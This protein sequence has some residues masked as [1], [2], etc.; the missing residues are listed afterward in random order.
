MFGFYS[1][2]YHSQ[3]KLYFH[4]QSLLANLLVVLHHKNACLNLPWVP[5]VMRHIYKWSICVALSKMA[6]ASKA[7]IFGWGGF[8]YKQILVYYKGGHSGQKIHFKRNN[9]ISTERGYIFFGNFNQM[10]N[11]P[12]AVFQD[13][14]KS[15]FHNLDLIDCWTLIII[16]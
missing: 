7:N 14:L 10:H 2:V 6:K 3:V 12:Y 4:W 5:C 1:L 13:G 8:S 11:M 16:L 9:L 15:N